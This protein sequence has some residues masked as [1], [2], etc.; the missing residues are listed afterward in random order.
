MDCFKV[1]VVK[2]DCKPP[3]KKEHFSFLFVSSDFSYLTSSVLR[4]CFEPQML[5]AFTKK[6]GRVR[7]GEAVTMMLDNLE[8]PR[9]GGKLMRRAGVAVCSTL[10]TQP[11]P[12]ISH[13]YIWNTVKTK[14]ITC[15][16]LR[17]DS[18]CYPSPYA[19]L[20]QVCT[21]LNENERI[22]KGQTQFIFAFFNIPMHME[23][24]T[25]INVELNAFH[26]E[27]NTLLTRK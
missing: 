14:R 22:N 7:H 16:T 2:L 10:S 23:L 1:F 13:C 11:Q 26:K 4:S 24:C 9:L 27:G 20:W 18:L 12:L 5:E 3:P 8:K 21:E 19:C 6:A 25:L 17:K 15:T